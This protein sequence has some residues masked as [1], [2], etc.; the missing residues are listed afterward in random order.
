MC[1]CIYA[2]QE[3]REDKGGERERES[4]MKETR[5]TRHAVEARFVATREGHDGA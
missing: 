3:Y 1:V 4:G 2:R 5:V